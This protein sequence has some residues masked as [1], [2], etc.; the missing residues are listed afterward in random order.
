MGWWRCEL[1]TRRRTGGRINRGQE[2]Q[3]ACDTGSLDRTLL[4]RHLGDVCV[5]RIAE[6]TV[7]AVVLNWQ[8]GV[9]A[10]VA[11][12]P[13][14]LVH[15]AG[16]VGAVAMVRAGPLQSV[17]QHVPARRRKLRQRQSANQ[18]RSQQKTH[19]MDGRLLTPHRQLNR[20]N[21]G[22]SGWIR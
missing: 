16:R 5:G 19:L 9:G 4:L 20:E 7:I 1:Q 12:R 15:P 21:C 10:L 11:S 17:M 6:Q 8:I 14:V 13:K 3:R 2:T 18:D 22:P